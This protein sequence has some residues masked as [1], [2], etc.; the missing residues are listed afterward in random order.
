MEMKSV[1]MNSRR[2]RRGLDDLK[3]LSGRVSDLRAVFGL[4]EHGTAAAS[5]V[6][7]KDYI[8]RLRITIQCG[9]KVTSV[10]TIDNKGMA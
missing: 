2:S 1:T 7:S 10:K 9:S 8:K 5:I 6:S 3:K 4:L